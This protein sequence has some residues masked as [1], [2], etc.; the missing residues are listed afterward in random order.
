[1]RRFI[2][3]VMGQGEGADEPALAQARELGA[4][5]AGEGW[6]VLSGGR[7]SGVMR[8]VNQ[9]AK[10][11]P[12]SLTLGILPS[13]VVAPSPDIDIVVVTDMHNARNNINVLSSDVVVACGPAGAGTASEIALALKAEKPVILLSPDAEAKALFLKL[14]QGRVYISDTPVETIAVIKTLVTI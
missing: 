1:M 2:V 9:G 3:G 13:S 8:A 12:G 11:I 4:L 7:D 14:G 6:I 5:I 10:Q